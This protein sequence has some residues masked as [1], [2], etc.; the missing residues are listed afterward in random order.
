MR[1]I[2]MALCIM[3]LPG[4]AAA[5]C[6]ES[7]LATDMSAAKTI[8]IATVT[9]ARL[10]RPLGELKPGDNY[11]VLYDFTVAKTIKGDPSVVS[12]L[13]TGGVFNSPSSAV[14]WDPAE[15]TKLIPGQSVLVVAQSTGIISVSDIG[16]TP[17]RPWDANAF[18]AV[19]GLPGL[20]P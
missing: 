7:P 4:P 11:A 20:A 16:C 5:I 19:K 14:Y 1:Y 2:A 13:S 18:R 6:L 9:G 17:S 10:D 3:A 8:F 15:Q 12:A